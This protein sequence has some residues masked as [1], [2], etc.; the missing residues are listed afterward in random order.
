MND[1]IEK[2]GEFYRNYSEKIAVKLNDDSVKPEDI[3]NIII[4]FNYCFLKK[5]DFFVENFNKRVIKTI[6]SSYNQFKTNIFT[7]EITD[8]F[9]GLNADDIKSMRFVII[10][11]INNYETIKLNNE[12]LCSIIS[13]D[14]VKHCLMKLNH[15]MN[16]K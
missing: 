5:N 12:E 9:Y 11:F 8:L 13:K 16:E 2:K 7:S 15:V 6:C 14:S 1:K 4:L 10:N 3:N